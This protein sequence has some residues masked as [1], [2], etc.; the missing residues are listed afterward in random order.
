MV[1]RMNQSNLK[2]ELDLILTSN[3]QFVCSHDDIVILSN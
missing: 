3:E 2:W 1:I